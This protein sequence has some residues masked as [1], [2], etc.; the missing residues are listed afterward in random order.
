MFIKFQTL[1]KVKNLELGERLSTDSFW[2]AVYLLRVVMNLGFI[3]NYVYTANLH[4]L[5]LPVSH[6]KARASV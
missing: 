4:V 3:I 2:L 1:L 6:L 5:L